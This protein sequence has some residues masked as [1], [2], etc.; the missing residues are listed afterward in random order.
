MISK[1]VGVNLF[2]SYPMDQQEFEHMIQDTDYHFFVFSS[3][4]VLPFHFALHTWIVVKYPNGE[5]V[6][7]DL[8]H[9]KN[10]EKTSLVYLHKNRLAPWRWIRKFFWKTDKHFESSL[11]Y[12]CSGNW[13]SLSYKIISFIENHIEEYPYKHHYRVVWHNSNHFTQWILNKFPE[14]NCILPRNAIGK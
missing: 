13:D 11:L 10:K 7:W 2:F 1:S 9:F 6:R 14:V 4:A 3:P 12:H 5:V 8:C